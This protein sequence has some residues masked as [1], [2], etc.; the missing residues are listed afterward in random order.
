MDNLCESLALY[1]RASSPVNKQ[2]GDCQWIVHGAIVTNRYLVHLDPSTEG[3]PL[4]FPVRD[5]PPSLS[6]VSQ[7]G[8]TVQTGTGVVPGVKGGVLL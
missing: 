1:Q 3:L 5:G 6:P 2:T 7:T 4:L 8:G